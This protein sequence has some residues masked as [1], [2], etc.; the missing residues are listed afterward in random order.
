MKSDYK[1]IKNYDDV[2]K[3]TKEKYEKECTSFE[4]SYCAKYNTKCIVGVNNNPICEV[5]NSG[6]YQKKLIG[7]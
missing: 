2:P 7:M 6:T 3:E 5:G 1:K 4:K